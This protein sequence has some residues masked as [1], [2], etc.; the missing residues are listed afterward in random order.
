[1][2]L[3]ADR[4][5]PNPAVRSFSTRMGA[6]SSN[7]MTTSSGAGSSRSSSQDGMPVSSSHVPL[8]S[9]WYAALPTSAPSM[10]RSRTSAT[11]VRMIRT[12]DHLDVV[13][14]LQA[15]II[16]PARATAGQPAGGR[17]IPPLPSRFLALL[18]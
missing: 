7:L 3:T 11:A 15:A 13:R 17:I 9:S 4:L 8:Q 14:R 16:S 6:G 5:R 2:P 12:G 18:R 1:M 10:A